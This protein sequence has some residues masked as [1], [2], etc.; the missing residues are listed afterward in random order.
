M[1]ELD[2]HLPVQVAGLGRDDSVTLGRVLN[3]YASNKKTLGFLP[4]SGFKDRVRRDTLLVATTGTGELAGYAMYDLPRRQVRLM[5]LCVTPV[6]RGSGVARALIE[7]ISRRHTDRTGILVRCRRDYKAHTMWPHLDF[8]PRGDQP[9]RG[10]GGRTLTVWWRDHGHPHLFSAQPDANQLLT[11]IDHNVFLDL[12]VRHGR[13]GAEESSALIS[14]WLGDQLVL[15]FAPELLVEIDRLPDAGDR[16]RQRDEATGTLKELTPIP[17]VFHRAVELL[18]RTADAAGKK[19]ELRSDTRHVAAAAAAGA[20][21]FVTR[22]NDLINVLGAAAAKHFGLRVLR[23]SD[24]VVHLDQLAQAAA[25][26][27]AALLGTG[28]SMSQLGPGGDTEIRQVLLDRAGGE[29]RADFDRRLRAAT[30]SQHTLR[31]VIRDPAGALVGFAASSHTIDE[32]LVPF[33]RTAPHHLESTLARQLLLILRQEARQLKVPRIRITD[34]HMRAT[35]RRALADE[36]YLQDGSTWVGA[37][38]DMC[39]SWAEIVDAA[40]AVLP[41][42]AESLLA[43]MTGRKPTATLASWVEHAWW[44]AKPL[45]ADLPTYIIP[46]KPTWTDDLFGLNDTLFARPDQLGM[47]REHVYYRSPRP[48][49]VTSP[50]R[51]LWYASGANRGGIGAIVA[52]SRLTDVVTDSP[53]ALHAQFHHLGVW[54]LHQIEA[55]AAKGLACAL[56]FADTEILPHPVSWERLRALT[57]GRPVGTLQSPTKI[58]SA[59]FA[60]IYQ[61]GSRGRS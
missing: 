54:K 11:A 48:Q 49:P 7:E 6:Y 31:R 8:A 3:L 37:V 5:H 35:V 15:A 26:H 42:S 18:D 29:R 27:P 59:T 14:D 52:C 16:Q 46:I 44:P 12:Y 10:S 50:G 4:D 34:P 28:F 17:S 2:A 13:P 30:A 60:A 53:A 38:I 1:G 20:H 19:D 24:V 39:G 9:G 25:Y 57:A 47:S 45:D 43:D 61:E 56:R 32:V 40:R 23:P 58:D 36:G 41:A 51:V 55:A 21:L 22:D 33:L